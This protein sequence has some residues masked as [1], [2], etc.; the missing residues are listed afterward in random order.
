M[1]KAEIIERVYETLGGSK[2]ECAN[3]VELTFDL[4]KEGLAG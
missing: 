4:I 2:Q 1:T 3:L